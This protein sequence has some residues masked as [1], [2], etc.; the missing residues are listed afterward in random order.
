MELIRTVFD[1]LPAAAGS[2]GARVVYA[3]GAVAILGLTIRW[4]RLKNEVGSNRPQTE[5]SSE[6]D[7][8]VSST[9]S[10]SILGSGD[11]GWRTL[12]A[13]GA[14]V[15]LVV[16]ALVLAIAINRAVR[17]RTQADFTVTCLQGQT[18]VA[19]PFSVRLKRVDRTE[20]PLVALEISSPSAEPMEVSLGQGETVHLTGD[21]EIQV[22]QIGFGITRFRFRKLR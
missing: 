10:T 20:R 17:F 1:H 2:L 8:L 21:F 7:D 3:I 18:A 16:V 11:I 15:C 5:I 12:A 13:K 9:F 4:Y 22:E 14:A 19:G 6:E